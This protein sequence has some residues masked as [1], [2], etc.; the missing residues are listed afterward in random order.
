MELRSDHPIAESGEDAD[1]LHRSTYAELIAKG[2]LRPSKAPGLVISIEAPWGAGKTSLM[3]LMRAYLDALPDDERPVTLVFNPWLVGSRDALIQAF[4]GQLSTAIGESDH[5]KAAKKVAKE[6]TNYSSAFGLLK[7][8]PGAEPFASIVKGVLEAAGK[9]VGDA[10]DVRQADLEARRAAVVEALRDFERPVVVFI[11]DLDR[12]PPQ[13]VFEVIRLVKAVAEFPRT[14]YVLGFD[15]NYVEKAL[16]TAGIRKTSRYLDKI[17]QVRLNVPKASTN[18]IRAIVNAEMADFPSSGDSVFQNH[19]ERLQELYHQ[20]LKYLFETP[21]DVK[22][23]RNRLLFVETTLQ[24]EVA[25]CDLLALETLAI[26]ANSVYQHIRDCP[27]AYTGNQPEEPLRLKGDEKVIADFADERAAALKAVPSPL[28]TAVKRIVKLLFPLVEPGGYG[29]GGKASFEAHGRIASASRL[30]VALSFGVPREE[31]PL[32]EAREFIDKP[33]ARA[34]ILARMLDGAGFL[35]FVEQLALLIE[36]DRRVMAVDDFITSL[37]EALNSP[38]GRVVDEAVVDMLMAPARQQVW[39]VCQSALRQLDV[40]ARDAALASL[41]S[42][43]DYLPVSS[44]AIRQCAIDLA[45]PGTVDTK[46][47][48]DPIC[49]KGAWPGLWKLWMSVAL[50]A[51]KDGSLFDGP[52]RGM[53]LRVLHAFDVPNAKKVFA[54]VKKHATALEGFACALVEGSRDS[55]KGDYA[56]FDSEFVAALVDLTKL[57]KALAAHASKV[58]VEGPAQVA[59]AVL[60]DGSSRYFVDGSLK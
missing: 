36:A 48:S 10:A 2:A 32:D 58:T 44:V 17:I 24:R 57:R 51:A 26:K 33:A 45:V 35:R 31:V 53:V 5:G 22:R 8:V 15:A 27:Q 18:D 37:A 46:P 25:F 52:V 60:R 12:I 47:S 39:W 41:M 28:Q 16:R 21:R 49:S 56:A 59:F 20:G 42:S 3:N 19:A 40:A 6:L 38:Q 7:F 4:L 54:L 9:A 29:S 11:D 23:V 13:E 30:R 14:S 1:L 55:R 50:G 34:D 43:A